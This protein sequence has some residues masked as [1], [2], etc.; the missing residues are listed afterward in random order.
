MP[1][2]NHDFFLQINAMIFCTLFD[3]NI[4]IFLMCLN[5]SNQWSPQKI[6]LSGS[7]KWPLF[8]TYIKSLITTIPLSIYFAFICIGTIEFQR[9][10]DDFDE[11]DLVTKFVWRSYFSMFCSHFQNQDTDSNPASNSF[12]WPIMTSCFS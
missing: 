9:L 12:Y 1:I 5:L 4:S 2:E 3:V 11:F 7:K 8:Y 10:Y 6:S